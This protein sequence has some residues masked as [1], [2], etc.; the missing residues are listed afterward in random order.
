MPTGSKLPIPRPQGLC[1]STIAC[2]GDSNTA[3]GWPTPE[4]RRWCQY[5]QA[6]CPRLLDGTPVVWDDFGVGGA[7]VQRGPYIDY[8]LGE[9]ETVGADVVVLA[10]GTNDRALETPSEYATNVQSACT[11]ASEPAD[12][13]CFVMSMPPHS[14][15]DYGAY[16]DAV[17]AV[18]PTELI[19]DRTTG[20]VLESD[21]AHLDDPSQQELGRRASLAICGE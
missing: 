9:A 18:V 12:A 16:N 17:A 8:E 14:G 5:A 6:D 7:V 11:R 2:L 1:V 19:I 15:V 13:P 4:T 3:G 10:F 21:N 20:M